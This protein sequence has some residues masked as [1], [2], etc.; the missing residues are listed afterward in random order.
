VS[1]GFEAKVN[2]SKQADLVIANPNKAKY[3]LELQ[4]DKDRLKVSLKGEKFLYNYKIN[5]KDEQTLKPKTIVQYSPLLLPGKTKVL[6]KG[7]EGQIIKI[8]R[9][10][11]QGNQL[12]ESKMISEDYY[13]PAYRVEVHGLTG[14]E[15]GTT[16]TTGTT[17]NQVGTANSNQ[18]TYNSNGNQTTTNSG[19]TQQT[20]DDSD[21]WGKP[22]EQPK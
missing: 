5:K 16:Q 10:V 18:T 13:P 15:R 8:Y 20:S 4:L 3:I 21:L 19:N 2:Q 9:D 6:A 11:Y 1:L 14:T 22:N 7:A 17:G 12:M